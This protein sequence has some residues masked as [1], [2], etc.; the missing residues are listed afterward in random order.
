MQTLFLCIGFCLRVAGVCVG[1]FA[2]NEYYYAS[3]FRLEGSDD[4]R[5]IVQADLELGGIFALSVL[6]LFAPS[7][8]WNAKAWFVAVAGAGFIWTAVS[9]SLIISHRE[10]DRIRSA[11]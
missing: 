6:L 2:L 10:Q 7:C 8:R 11:P 3:W 1:L 5:M 9:S 4:L